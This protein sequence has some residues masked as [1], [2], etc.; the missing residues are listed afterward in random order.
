MRLPLAL[1]L[2]TLTTTA[3]AQ[4]W[5]GAALGQ[6][7]DSLQ[8]QFNNA[9][10]QV[11]LPPRRRPP[12]PTPPS[13]S[14]SPAFSTPF[15]MM[16]TFHFDTNSRLAE[17][18]LSLDLPAMRHD[19]AAL[20][21]DESLFA[22]AA[23]KLAFVFSGEYGAPVF[24][25]TSCNAETTTAPCTIEWRINPAQ[26]VQLERIPAGHHLRIHYLPTAAPI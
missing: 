19:Y 6:S 15:P 25:T 10:L 18:S 5:A 22:F 26:V 17:T 24:A 9:N 8:T 12:K 23:D 14:L 1:L 20:G 4:T 11:S 3:S 13:P 2:A 7:R 21:S 16:A